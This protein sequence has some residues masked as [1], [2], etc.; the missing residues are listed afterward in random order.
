MDAQP[1]AS[2]RVFAGSIP[3]FYEKYL[4]PLIFQPYADEVAGRL[5]AEPPSALLEIAAG[6]GVLTR[7]LAKMLPASTSIVATDL[8][9]PM[10]DLAAQIGTARPVT[11][12]QADAFR[13][14]FADATFDAVACQFGVMFLPDKTAAFSEAR[15]VLRPGGRFIFSV[16]DR[17][18]DNEFA[19][20]VTAAVAALFPDDPPNFLVRTPHGYHDPEAIGRDLALGGFGAAGFTTSAA[21]SKAASPRI[22]AVAYCRG[23]PLN[24]EIVDRDPSR[25]DEATDAAASAIARRFGNG[26]VD[27]KIQAYIVTAGV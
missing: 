8:N 25:L 18:E 16:W 14:P 19:D 23:T 24:S 20:V 4:V 13:L 26:S 2:D 15:R 27:G 10:L 22:P 7:S 5:V 1:Q 3:E 12:Q 21:R 17:I 9:L 6:T 11:W